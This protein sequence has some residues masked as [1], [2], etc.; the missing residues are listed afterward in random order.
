[1]SA[2]DDEHEDDGRK[3]NR[4]QK[5]IL[6]VPACEF[7]FCP[8]RSR[9]CRVSAF[10]VW[11]GC[12]SDGNGVN[13]FCSCLPLGEMLEPEHGKMTKEIVDGDKCQSYRNS[14]FSISPSFSLV[15]AHYI[16]THLLIY[17][18]VTEKHQQHNS[19]K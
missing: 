12:L 5:K 13:L 4:K 19:H 8:G 10:S 14:V 18:T 2:D 17:R 16:S 7:C 3:H 11:G 15:H 6:T 9:I 1:M